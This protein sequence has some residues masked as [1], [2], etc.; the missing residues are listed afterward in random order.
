EGVTN[1]DA[2]A[3]VEGLDMVLIGPFDLSASLGYPAEFDRPEH[4]EMMTR[5]IAAVKDAGKYLGTTPYGGRSLDQLY[6]RGFDLIVGKPDVSMLRDS[7]LEQVKMKQ[8]CVAAL[9]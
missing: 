8:A 4:Q 5:T 7:A 9:R 1:A 3:A 6:E 2:I